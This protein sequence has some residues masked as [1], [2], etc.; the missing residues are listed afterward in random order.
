MHSG[1]GG[2]VLSCVQR[3]KLL[4]QTHITHDVERKERRPFLN[5][6]GLVFSRAELLDELLALGSHAG[7]VA[8]Q[9]CNTRESHELPEMPL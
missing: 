3:A 2:M 4:A 9:R 1:D 7:N 8:I 5:V 6:D